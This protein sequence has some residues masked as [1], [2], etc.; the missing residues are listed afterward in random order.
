[1][2]VFYCLLENGNI[3]SKIKISKVTDYAA[4][5]LYDTRLQTQ[6]R[7]RR[8]MTK[9]HT[10]KFTI[11]DYLTAPMGRE[12]RHVSTLRLNMFNLR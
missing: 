12:H 9:T 11:T 5:N 6:R 8:T 7:L 3:S 2:L 4:L 1:M 10:S